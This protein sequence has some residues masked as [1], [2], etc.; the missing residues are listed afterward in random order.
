MFFPFVTRPNIIMF[1]QICINP[2]SSL[3]FAFTEKLLLSL[4]L[5]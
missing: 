4:S 5:S 3:A 1:E 2:I